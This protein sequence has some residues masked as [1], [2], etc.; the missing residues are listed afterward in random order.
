M[1]PAIDIR[2]VSKT[3]SGSKFPVLSGLSLEVPKGQAIAILG[4][5]GAGKTTLMKILL[6]L[7]F[8]DSGLVSVL[9]RSPGHAL[10]R[11]CIGYLSELPLTIEYL[12]KESFLAHFLGLIPKNTSTDTALKGLIDAL[13]G[14]IPTGLTLQGYSKGMMQRLNFARVLMSDPDLLFLDEP[15]TG[16]DPIGQLTMESMVSHLRNLQKTIYINTHSIEFAYKAADRILVM[17]QGQIIRDVLVED[18]TE[19]ELK[20]LFLNLPSFRS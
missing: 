7:V 16:L 19:A 15:A 1:S 9:D 2:N 3:Y 18:G 4:P 6:G 11:S 17:H 13:I 8:A 5:N 10:T 12:D 20:D 14:N